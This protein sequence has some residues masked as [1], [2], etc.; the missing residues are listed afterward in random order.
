MINCALIGR[1][2]SSPRKECDETKS[3]RVQPRAIKPSFD[4]TR[5]RPRFLRFRIDL[6]LLLGNRNSTRKEKRPLLLRRGS[7]EYYDSSN[8]RKIW[9]N[10]SRRDG[11]I[12]ISRSNDPRPRLCLVCDRLASARRRML[13]A[14]FTGLITVNNAASCAVRIE[15]NVKGSMRLYRNKD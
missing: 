13:A 2:T 10:R 8:F 5:L 12:S 6:F 1:T 15:G 14:T 9:T 11:K 7:T 3:E 4:S